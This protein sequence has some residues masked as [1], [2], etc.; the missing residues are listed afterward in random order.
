MRI[1]LEQYE[2]TYEVEIEQED[3]SADD[4]IELFTRIL[5][6]A[7]YPPSV[8]IPKDDE[9]GSYH[10]VCPDETITRRE[11]YDKENSGD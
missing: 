6:V 10:F 7:G 4:L 1:T 9:Q 8:I 3:M 11:Q 2:S 5:V